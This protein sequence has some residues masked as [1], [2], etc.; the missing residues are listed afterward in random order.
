RVTREFEDDDR[1]LLTA[2]GGQMARNL[3]R[4]EAHKASRKRSAVAFLSAGEADQRLESL[5]VLSGPLFDQSAGLNAV[6]ELG[7]R[8]ALGYLE[9]RTADVNAALAKFAGLETEN[10][11]NIP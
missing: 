4:E 10:I 7:E 1:A 5:N 6:G 11:P 8:V 9:G 3:Q 2:I